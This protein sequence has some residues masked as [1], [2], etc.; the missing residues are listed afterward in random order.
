[1]DQR[2]FRTCPS[3]ANLL[4]LREL[5]NGNMDRA[6]ADE[7]RLRIDYI[8]LQHSKGEMPCFRF[9][10]GSHFRCRQCCS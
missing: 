2:F 4:S 8:Q 3:D 1:M 5:R 6:E 10:I 9:S 7:W